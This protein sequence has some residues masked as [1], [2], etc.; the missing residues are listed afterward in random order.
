LVNGELLDNEHLKKV[1][2]KEVGVT[3]GKNSV[4]LLS[5]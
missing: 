4:C 5:W 2:D 3:G 1:R